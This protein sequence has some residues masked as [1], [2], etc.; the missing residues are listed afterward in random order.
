MENVIKRSIKLRPENNPKKITVITPCSRPENLKKIKLNFDYIREWIIVY[1]GP[2]EHQFTENPKI[3]EYNFTETN[4]I[5]GTAQRNFALQ[6]V[7]NG[8]VYFLDDDNTIHP[9][10]YTLLH[11]I[12]KGHFYTFNQKRKNTLRGN[13]LKPGFIDTSMFLIDI[14]LAKEISWNNS[15]THDGEYI[16]TIYNLFPQSWIFINIVLCYYNK[17]T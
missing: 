15:L 13:N 6:L 10:F 3:S 12:E 16:Q 17:L 14:A 1:D 5:K 4:S 2:L 8:F 7:E 9:S 11:F